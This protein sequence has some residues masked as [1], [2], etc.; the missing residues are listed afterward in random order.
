MPPVK[1]LPK[2]CTF[3]SDYSNPGGQDG[4]IRRCRAVPP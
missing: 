4:T 3:V 2:E 1:R